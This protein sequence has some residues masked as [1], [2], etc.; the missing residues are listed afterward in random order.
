MK[1][2]ILML[3]AIMIA[4]C[5]VKAINIE[6]PKAAVEDN[7]EYKSPDK[8]IVALDEIIK[9][10]GKMDRATSSTMRNPESGAILRKLSIVPFSS[11]GN[12]LFEKDLNVAINAFEEDKDCAYN[13]SRVNKMDKKQ[14]GISLGTF[15]GEDNNDYVIIA[16]DDELLTYNA[17]IMEVK[18]AD[19]PT[20][21]DFYAIKWR[22]MP[23]GYDGK[24]FMITSKRPDLI[25][26]QTIEVEEQAE[27]HIED[28]FSG[29]QRDKFVLLQK[30]AAMYKK[31]IDRLEKEHSATPQSNTNVRNR[32]L[33]EMNR[34]SQRYDEVISQMHNMIRL[35]Q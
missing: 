22:K 8:V 5:G 16:D 13:Y 27:D 32:K 17:I 18:N 24:V 7:S 23:Q 26:C 11:E 15:T 35:H 21:R 2:M 30:T 31:E 10:Y 20:K 25:L 6:Q 28:F 33:D 1:K 29:S 19:D 9:K 3:A 34:M 12:G 4:S 14:N